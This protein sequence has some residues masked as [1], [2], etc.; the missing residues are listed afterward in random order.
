MDQAKDTAKEAAL[1]TGEVLKDSVHD[2]IE[3]TGAEV[4]AFSQFFTTE[5]LVDIATLGVLM[6][7][8]V[9]F[10]I[11]IY[12]VLV[13]F[14]HQVIRRQKKRLDPETHQEIDTLENLI[15]SMLFYL[16]IFVAGV[17]LLSMV[18]INMRGLIA[19]AGVAGLAIAFISQSIIKDWV[20]GIF[21]IIEKEYKV[22]DWVTIAGKTGQV[23]ALGMRS[24]TM[25]A[26]NGETIIIPN[27]TVVEITNHS[28][29]PRISFVTIPAP[30]DV[31]PDLIHRALE[32]AMARVNADYADRLVSPVQV[33]GPSSMAET[34][35][36][37][38][39]SFSSD[40]VSFYPLNRAIHLEALK[41]YR[42]YGF[43]IPHQTYHRL[44][45][46]LGE[47]DPTPCP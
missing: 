13:R 37:Y 18:G 16:F 5:K 4:S 44:K 31:D 15:Q 42:A 19:S 25:V 35:L 46:M 26:S 24:T 47:E 3:N 40:Y 14:L 28:N 33:L 8:T 39:I 9:L 45:D 20:T 10:F 41:A 17:T 6:V 43:A 32:E 11:L 23:Q 27:G 29:L 2:T 38:T 36:L 21:I 34:S 30:Y 7:V 1:E 22:G 12:K